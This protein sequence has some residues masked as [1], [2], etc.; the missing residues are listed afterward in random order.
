MPALLKA[1]S[2]N[3]HP[4]KSEECGTRKNQEKAH[5]HTVP[6]REKREDRANWPTSSFPHS[7]FTRMNFG[8]KC[9]DCK[10]TPGA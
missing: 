3:P 10:Y 4:S 1:Q 9:P 5:P 2:Q 8:E 7:E 6:L